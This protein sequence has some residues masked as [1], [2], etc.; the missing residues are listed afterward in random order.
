M[1]LNE[2]APKP[3]ISQL[4]GKASKLCPWVGS[5]FPVSYDTKGHP[6]VLLKIHI[7]YDA[8]SLFVVVSW[9]VHYGIPDTNPSSSPEEAFDLTRTEEKGIWT[10]ARELRTHYS[11]VATH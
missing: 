4:K 3:V 8:V 7:D 2:W 9:S 11:P 1:A 6:S 10:N 5:Q